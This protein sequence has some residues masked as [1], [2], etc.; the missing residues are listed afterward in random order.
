MTERLVQEH[1]LTRLNEAAIRAI[2][3]VDDGI[4]VEPFCFHIP[5]IEAVRALAAYADEPVLIDD[6]LIYQLGCYAP[7]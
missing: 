4:P 2:L 5:N 6:T 7:G 1:H 3:N